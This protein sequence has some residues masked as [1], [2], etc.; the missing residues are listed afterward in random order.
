MRSG[1]KNAGLTRYVGGLV[2]NFVSF[3]G[4]AKEAD[5]KEGGGSL[6]EKESRGGPKAEPSSTSIVQPHVTCRLF[7]TS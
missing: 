3:V 1:K 4:E 2:A 7:V 5:G 6:W